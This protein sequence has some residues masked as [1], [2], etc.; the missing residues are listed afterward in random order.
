MGKLW[1]F[2]FFLKLVKV[3]IIKSK[4]IQLLEE[5]IGKYSHN[6]MKKCFLILTQKAEPINKKTESLNN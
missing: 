2:F 4:T 3:F 5:N 1:F 6:F